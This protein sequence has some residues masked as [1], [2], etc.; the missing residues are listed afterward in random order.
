M[1]T[2]LGFL[3][4]F[5]TTLY[6]SFTPRH[7]KSRRGHG[8]SVGSFHFAQV[9]ATEFPFAFTAERPKGGVRDTK[10]E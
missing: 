10:M 6:H 9:D 1:G 5:P 8:G 2:A 3:S 7:V 4:P